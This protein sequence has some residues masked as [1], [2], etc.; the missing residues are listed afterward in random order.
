MVN[1]NNPTTLTH[2]K[3]LR[4]EEKVVQSWFS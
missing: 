1:L 2:E 3:K 4:P